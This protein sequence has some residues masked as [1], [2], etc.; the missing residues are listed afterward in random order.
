MTYEQ[1]IK[2][3]QGRKGLKSLEEFELGILKA[4]DLAYSPAGSIKPKQF[5]DE[6]NRVA[7]MT[8][9]P[10]ALSMT[11]PR[12]AKLKARCSNP[13]FVKHWKAVIIYAQTVP[14]YAGKKEGYNGATINSLLDREGFAINII[15]RLQHDQDKPVEYK[16]KLSPAEMRRRER[17]VQ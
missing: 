1:Y 15:E 13:L 10:K 17:E 12:K 8:G 5:M 11:A 14:H 4:H 16:N 7:A 3:L 2:L 9:R 6:W